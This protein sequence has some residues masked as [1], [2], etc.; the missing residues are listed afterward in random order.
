MGKESLSAGPRAAALLLSALLLAA[1]PA[2]PARAQ[3]KPHIVLGTSPAAYSAAT[4]AP[5]FVAR[6][7][8]ANTAILWLRPNTELAV[9]PYVENPTVD[10][11][12]VRLRLLAGDGSTVA[13]SAN[14]TVPGKER[15]KPNAPPRVV[16]LT[17]APP[18]PPKEPVAAPPAPAAKEAPPSPWVNGDGLPPQFRL[19]LEEIETDANNKVT[20]T[21]LDQMAV[22]VL[23][24]QWYVT[25]TG[26]FA[27]A[28]NRL[29]V[30]VKP[31][32]GVFK[33]FKGGPCPLRLSVLLPDPKGGEPVLLDAPK[34]AVLDRPLTVGRDE[35]ELT[36]ADPRL[37]AL[38]GKA[39][40]EGRIVLSVDDYDHAF[41]FESGFEAESGL[42]P[43]TRLKEPTLRLRAPKAWAPGIDLP[44]R[45]AVDDIL[46]TLPTN[47]EALEVTLRL[48][49]GRLTKAGEFDAIVGEDLKGHRMQ[50]VSVNPQA[51]KGALGLRAESRDWD[52]ALPTRGIVGARRLR[53]SVPGRERGAI[54]SVEQDVILDATPPVI[55]EMGARKRKDDPL[56][57]V[58]LGAGELTMFAAGDDPES[59]I[60]K[61]VF[62]LG[63]PAEDP[64]VKGAYKLPEGAT[65]VRGERPDKKADVWEA[66]LPVGAE[67]P[68]FVDVGVQFV[69]NAGLVTFG[70]I[71]VEL[72]VPGPVVVKPGA[73]EGTVLEGD[74]PQPEVPVTL[75]DAAGVVRGTV[76]ADKATG[77]FKFIDLPPGAYRVSSAKSS[78]STSGTTPVQVEAGTTTKD[79]VIR[80]A[81]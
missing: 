13:E 52:V 75:T 18:P 26:N 6:E 35:V 53:A 16:R 57:K 76:A 17:L 36:V 9:F 3:G 37:A 51:A 73:I 62:F 31:K 68:G 32:E 61:V 46:G 55:T 23:V 29:T 74:R 8:G 38:K 44:A 77:K 11:R 40:R 58:A 54:P 78:D 28:D 34:D 59:G 25:A 70:T 56:P 10:Q 80:L 67:K 24:P 2:A 42:T 20:E 39:G 64:K 45:V 14:A 15:G 48:D 47:E 79:V 5:V 43:L 60:D 63:K 33:G 30:T 7:T 81:R 1:G 66:K 49:L 71:K 72:V 12:V 21:V 41:R 50:R 27:A 69:N 22:A 4:A 19:K 65:L